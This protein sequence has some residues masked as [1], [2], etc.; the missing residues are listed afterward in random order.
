MTM[1]AGA[2][3][4]VGRGNQNAYLGVE[5]N[6]Y[7]TTGHQ[8]TLQPQFSAIPQPDFVEDDSGGAYIDACTFVI[9]K[10]ETDLLKSAIQPLPNDQLK[11]L[12]F[13][14]IQAEN[15]LTDK[16]LNF[17]D[18]TVNGTQLQHSASDWK[19]C[20]GFEGRNWSAEY[21]ELLL[22]KDYTSKEWRKEMH[23]VSN[24][25]FHAASIYAQII[26]SELSL[27][28]SMKSIQPV[29][30]GGVAGGEKYV[31]NNI[32]FKFAT[33]SQLGNTNIYMYGGTHPR[34][35]LAM[36]VASIEMRNM[37]T[38]L[39]ERD[40]THLLVPL[41]C[42][43]DFQ[44]HRVFASSM[45]NIDDSTLVYGSADAGKTV[46]RSI[47]A[48]NEV[49]D[50]LG[51]RLNLK[52]HLTGSKDGGKELVMPGDIEVHKID[53]N[54]YYI[55]DLA[56]LMPPEA[57]KSMGELG[58]PESRKIFY[59]TLRPE[60]VCDYTE[61]LS[62][63]AFSGWAQYDSDRV[64]NENAV[65]RC[66][67]Y[68]RTNVIPTF[69]EALENFK[70][71]AIS[72][73]PSNKQQWMSMESVTLVNLLNVADMSA[74]VHYYGI[75]VRHLGLVRSYTQK[76]AFRDFL[77]IQ[78]MARVMKNIFREDMRII[79]KNS[80]GSPTDMPL[81]NLVLETYNKIH[82]YKRELSNP[83]AIAAKKEYWEEV[84]IKTIEQFEGC[85]SE[86][87][88]NIITNCGL[89]QYLKNLID[90][91]PLL[92]LFFKFAQVQL[93]DAAKEQMLKPSIRNSIQV[94]SDFRLVRSDVEKF[95]PKVRKP[96]ITGI[97]TALLL[98]DEA[99]DD[100]IADSNS[101]RLMSMATKE[102]KAA[103]QS[104][105]ACPILNR[106][107]G[108]LYWRQAKLATKPKR[109]VLQKFHA[110]RHYEF[111]LSPDSSDDMKSR[112]ALLLDETE[113]ELE[114]LKLCPGHIAR[115]RARNR[116]EILS[117]VSKRFQSEYP[118]FES[119]SS[120]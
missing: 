105:P 55:L 91:R 23:S 78:I 88:M 56:R 18:K 106:L 38:I 113:N 86:E 85:F 100:N 1:M 84:Y 81:R 46:R 64:E 82:P 22:T 69:S 74:L 42:V 93:T 51:N 31:V 68:L 11:E 90:F 117:S 63:D 39:T 67:E 44:G 13:Q 70:L 25:F 73:M 103:H 111:A 52:H 7:F 10:S 34:D 2:Y 97:A 65:K 112:F 115:I 43:I 20:T 83:I 60:L 3:M 30:I 72:Y 14:F 4:A 47:D 24:D 49:V 61:K 87:E 59:Q 33:D 28:D 37:Q 98:A 101:Y 48:V 108:D 12:V 104:A 58:S 41:M 45:L 40:G 99:E 96:Y 116:D 5:S 118:L 107:L 27:P 110:I 89:H 77:L 35:D 109:A 71:E 29:N 36:K 114:V 54:E 9:Q 80:M 76:S 53:D 6:C 17:H 57:P 92:Y 62:S 95:I 102:L 119:E 26:I 66:T 19:K 8:N 15:G 50:D 32:L 120:E 79:M 75:N 16:F 21:S 94:K